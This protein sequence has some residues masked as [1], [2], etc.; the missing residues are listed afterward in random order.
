V[1]FDFGKLQVR[2]WTPFV[3]AGAGSVLF[4]GFGVNG[5]VFAFH[6]GGGVTYKVKNS[7][8]VRFDERIFRINSFMGSGAT[9]NFQTTAV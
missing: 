9:A 5:Q 3:T 2:K 4:R 8:G 1:R 7:F 6:G